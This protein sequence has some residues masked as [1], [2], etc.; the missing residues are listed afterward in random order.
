MQEHLPGELRELPVAHRTLLAKPGEGPV[1]HAHQRHRQR[2][3]Q[4]GLSLQQ[5]RAQFIEHEG[6]FADHLALAG[7]DDFVLFRTQAV[8]V[9][10]QHEV[11][12][13]CRLVNPQK[14]VQ[15]F[16]KLRFRPQPQPAHLPD[17][18]HQPLGVVVKN[19]E[20]DRFLAG[21][22]VVQPRLGGAAAFSQLRD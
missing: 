19:L 16:P 11:R 21:E 9:V 10:E 2:L 8:E 20:E 3:A 14:A 18:L 4:F 6:E 7:R 13:L 1:D 15:E 12:G 5:I 17:D 22:V